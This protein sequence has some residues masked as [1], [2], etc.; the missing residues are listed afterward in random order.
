MRLWI[1]ILLW[2]IW[3]TATLL[4]SSEAQAARM[5]RGSFLVQ[6]AT[7]A[8]QLA[9]QVRANPVVASRYARHFG[10]PAPE[11]AQYAQTHLGLRR[12]PRGGVFRVFFIR[13][14]GDVESR[15]RYLPKGTRVFLHLR[16]G[17]PVLLGTCGNPLT[18][19][20]PGYPPP[21]RVTVVPPR[22]ITPPVAPPR[23]PPLLE[24]AAPTT[25][26]D[27]PSPPD[28]PPL[29]PISLSVWQAEPLAAQSE[30][31]LEPL[32][33]RPRAFPLLPL[34]IVAGLGLSQGGDVSVNP[35][36]PIPE[37]A[38]AMT[39]LA[40]AALLVVTHRTS[41]RRTRWVRQRL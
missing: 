15:A 35:P 27:L 30:P 32:I 20:L 11:F 1:T 33:G 22:V 28:P 40:G 36:V 16:S 10:V 37:P 3:L 18:S 39:L 4:V 31:A 8:A 6:P 26:L 24:P 2:L 7:S 21:R 12:L 9:N 13:A 19:V 14:D 25:L 38:S 23:E 5:P 29:V 17:Q 34:F 41:S